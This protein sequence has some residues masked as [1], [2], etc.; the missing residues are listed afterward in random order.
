MCLQ[1]NLDGMTLA[2]R[3]PTHA[4]KAH[5][6]RPADIPPFTFWRVGGWSTLADAFL[7]FH[8][9]AKDGTLDQYLPGVVR[10]HPGGNPGANLKSISHGCYLF[11]VAFVWDLTN[12]TLVLPLGCLQGGQTAPRRSVPGRCG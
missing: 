3:R 7:S 2:W 9:E 1:F 4:E 8:Q 6:P 11:E 12:E 5:A 10:T